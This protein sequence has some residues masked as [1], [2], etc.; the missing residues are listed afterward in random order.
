VLRS[1]ADPKWHPQLKS[2]LEHA[3][4]HQQIINRFGRFPH[5][6]TALGRANTKEELTYLQKAKTFGQ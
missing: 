1:E 3:T 4:E 2:F 6:N 5:R